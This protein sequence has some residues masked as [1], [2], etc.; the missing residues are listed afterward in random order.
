[1]MKVAEALGAAPGLKPV[2]PSPR[3]A[4]AS[5]A[6]APPHKPA[7]VSTRPDRTPVPA[8]APTPGPMRR[9]RP[10]DGPARPARQSAVRSTNPVRSTRVKAVTADMVRWTRQQ[11]GLGVAVEFMADLFDVAAGDLAD[12][13]DDG[14]QLARAA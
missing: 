5:D 8:P 3:R 11:M 10:T 14:P 13:L 4:A 6:P 9:P 1:V 2:A 7:P 12:A